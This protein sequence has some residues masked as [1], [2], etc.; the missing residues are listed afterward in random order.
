M[1]PPAETIRIGKLRDSMN[2]VARRALLGCSSLTTDRSLLLEGSWS[3]R[4]HDERHWSLD[5]ALDAR[6]SWIDAEAEQMAQ[7]WGAQ[8]WLGDSG[9]QLNAAWL[10]APRF[11][12]WLVKMLRV[13]AG[14]EVFVGERREPLQATLQSGRDMD[15]ATILEAWARHTRTPLQFTWHDEPSGDRGDLLDTP[16]VARWRRG[17]S[18]LNRQ[19]DVRTVDTLRNEQRVVLCG[20]PRILDPVCGELLRR[21]ARP[22]WLYERF[23]FHAWRRWRWRGVGQWV[24]DRVLP[25]DSGCRAVVPARES[26]AWHGIE[27]RAAIEHWLSAQALSVGPRQEQLWQQVRHALSVIRPAV[28]VVDQDA[29]PLN[30]LLVAAAR[31]RRIKSFVVQ[32]GVPYV[33]FG[34]APLEADYFCAWGMSTRTTLLP[35]GVNDE[36]ILITGSPQHDALPRSRRQA[37]SAV[38]PRAA[39]PRRFVLLPTVAPRDDRPDA[40]AYHCTRASYE[41]LLR[42]VFETLAQI[43]GCE[44]LV[45]PHPR[46]VPPRLLQQLRREFPRLNMRFV[47]GGSLAALIKRADCVISC[48]STSGVEA[49]ALGA[50][51]IQMMPVGSADLIDAPAWGMIGTARTSDELRRLIELRGSIPTAHETAWR[52]IVG[53]IDRAAA[54]QIVD[55]LLDPSLPWPHTLETHVKRPERSPSAATVVAS[56]SKA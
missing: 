54:P 32:H 55:A 38:D 35:W 34:Y 15:Y 52:S 13:L 1:S 16:P 41:Q 4:E 2:I 47:R 6:W 50:Q 33:R 48:A 51:V 17:L 56:R 3:P 14:L 45:R 53:E 31:E 11:R 29:T 30:R 28:V 39:D 22:W 18:W 44:L 20:N 19:T 10:N 23:A 7:A 42:T 26:C 43:E 49:A 37:V 8:P 21:R 27:L 36:R 25:R 5:D 40:Q 24:C 46:D 12:Y 9:R